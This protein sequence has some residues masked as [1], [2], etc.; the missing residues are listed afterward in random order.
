MLQNDK[1]QRNFASK[2]GKNDRN[3]ETSTEKLAKNSF[4]E[5]IRNVSFENKTEKSQKQAL[6]KH[7][8][9]EMNFDENSEILKNKA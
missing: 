6:P 5:N 3:F 7:G 4:G 1:F 2:L 8:Y 9:S